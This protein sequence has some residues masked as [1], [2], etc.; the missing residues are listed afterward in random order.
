MGPGYNLGFFA[1]FFSFVLFF[2]LYPPKYFHAA[3]YSAAIKPGGMGGMVGH[4]KYLRL[5]WM[6]F[7]WIKNIKNCL[8]KN[9]KAFFFFFLFFVIN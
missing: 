8:K 3:C 6:S 9:N 5:Y 7:I 4:E 2:S 1:F